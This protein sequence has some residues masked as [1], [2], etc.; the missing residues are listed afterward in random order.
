M[1]FNHRAGEWAQR[2][3]TGRRLRYDISFNPTRGR[4]N[5]DASW[6]TTPAP[7]V[8]LDELRA[9][10]VLGVDLNA[11]HLTACVLDAAGNL[12]GCTR[13]DRCRNDG[14]ASFAV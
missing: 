7:A 13:H 6:I 10:R 5:V 8:G 12:I 4:W 3:L 1:T 14:V 11:D 2:W 9:R